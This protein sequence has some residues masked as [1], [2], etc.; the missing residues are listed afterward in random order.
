[1]YQPLLCGLWFAGLLIIANSSSCSENTL[2]LASVQAE[3]KAL[4]DMAVAIPLLTTITGITSILFMYLRSIQT[5]NGAT[6]CASSA[7][8]FCIHENIEKSCCEDS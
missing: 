2:R 6:T 8:N 5:I 1:M 3:G 7:R 4:S